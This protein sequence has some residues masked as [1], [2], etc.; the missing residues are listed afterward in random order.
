MHNHA[1][2]SDYICIYSMHCGAVETISLCFRFDE[3]LTGNCVCCLFIFSTNLG[4]ISRKR[5]FP[6][7]SILSHNQLFMITFPLIMYP[8]YL[9][10]YLYILTTNR[11]VFQCPTYN[12]IYNVPPT[13]RMRCKCPHS[14]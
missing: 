14:I 1:S 11:L 13:Y 5:L 8:K 2:G 9:N 12:C 7:S 4:R 10:I 3:L 6:L